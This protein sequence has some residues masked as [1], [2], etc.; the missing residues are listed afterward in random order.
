MKLKRSLSLIGLVVIV[1]L[2]AM[3]G[4]AAATDQTTDINNITV[5]YDE[6]IIVGSDNTANFIVDTSNSD[7]Y[8][9]SDVDVI[10]SAPIGSQQAPDIYEGSISESDIGSQA[11]E[12]TTYNVVIGGAQEFSFAVTL[13]TDTSLSVS[14]V[15]VYSKNT[16]T[17]TESSDP[18]PP[19]LVT[20]DDDHIEVATTDGSEITDRNVAFSGGGNVTLKDSYTDEL[21]YS[22]D[23]PGNYTIEID[24]SQWGTVEIKEQTINDHKA[25]ELD[26]SELKNATTVNV[27]L[28]GDPANYDYGFE[29]NDPYTI[30]KFEVGASEFGRSVDEKYND[31]TTIDI[32]NQTLWD[33]SIGSSVETNDTTTVW[34]S[35]AVDKIQLDGSTEYDDG[36]LGGGGGGES[37]S[38]II[39]VIVA[40]A[41]VALV[42]RD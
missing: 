21:H 35:S 12:S 28:S 27:T 10:G 1:G 41:A 7:Q 30:I 32:S 34:V 17:T 36:L 19:S 38:L 2:T 14:N 8:N 40:G 25:V 13:Q 31:S 16:I 9:A 18:I 11:G 37:G 6:N 24:G 5:A 22:V 15:N 23:S 3:V 4:P 26:T 29:R 33:S 39:L 20:Y 42:L